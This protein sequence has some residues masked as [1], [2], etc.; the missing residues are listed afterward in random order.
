MSMKTTTLNQSE[1][2]RQL[3]ALATALASAASVPF[4]GTQLNACEVAVL[5]GLFRAR[6]NWWQGNLSD[7]EL[8]RIRQ[9]LLGS[10]TR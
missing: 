7:S 5:A 10:V 1:R 4:W 6:L 3:D 9:Q 2:L 8:Q